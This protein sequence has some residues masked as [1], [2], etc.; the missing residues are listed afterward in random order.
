MSVVAAQQKSYLADKKP[1]FKHFYPKDVAVLA[2][3]TGAMQGLMVLNAYVASLDLENDEDED[4]D[5]FEDVDKKEPFVPPSP[6]EFSRACAKSFT[7]SISITTYT[8]SLEEVSLLYFSPRLVGK[9]VKG[10]GAGY[11]I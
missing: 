10:E 5:G 2:V 4:D 3:R 6:E 9:L 7:K 8:R 1:F 11:C